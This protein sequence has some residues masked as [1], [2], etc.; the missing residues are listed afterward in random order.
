MLIV[1]GNGAPKKKKPVLFVNLNQLVRLNSIAQ[2]ASSILFKSMSHFCQK[3]LKIKN[4]RFVAYAI[5]YKLIFIN[6][7]F[8]VFIILI[9]SINKANSLI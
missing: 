9:C 8:H 3:L 6:E 4:G 1:F 7:I 5:I 2:N